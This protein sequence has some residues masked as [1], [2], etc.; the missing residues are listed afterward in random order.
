MELDWNDFHCTVSKRGSLTFLQVHP[1]FREK[2]LGNRLLFF[3]AETK[4]EGRH[5]RWVKQKPTR[6]FAKQAPKPASH[7][8]VTVI[9]FERCGTE[10]C[11]ITFYFFVENKTLTGN[12]QARRQQGRPVA[13]YL[14]Y[15]TYLGQYFK[16]H[17][18]SKKLS[19]YCCCRN[20]S[21][22]S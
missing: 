16:Q 4:V 13:R 14:I 19:R 3:V 2:L 9:L 22:Y 12:K 11:K 8:T 20:E 15:K 17:K 7:T 10:A 18:I 5:P 6:G 1:R 21:L